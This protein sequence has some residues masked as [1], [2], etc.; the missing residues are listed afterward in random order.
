[1][2]VAIGICLH[3]VMDDV[4]SQCTM[5]TSRSTSLNP[6]HCCI[7]S[8]LHLFGSATSLS[9]QPVLHPFGLLCV[10]SW[11]CIYAINGCLL[12]VSTASPYHLLVLHISSCC[13]ISV[14]GAAS[15]CLV[16]HLYVVLAASLQHLL[17]LSRWCCTSAA[18]TC[19]RIYMTGFASLHLLLHLQLGLYLCNWC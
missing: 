1:M 6:L 16:L 19:Y 10:S 3:L 2:P 7:K 12:A 5:S 17:H 8:V 15:L 11:C 14:T 4:C 18:A 13:C 9:L